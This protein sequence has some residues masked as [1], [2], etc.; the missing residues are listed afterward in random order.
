MKYIFDFDEV[1]LFTHKHWTDHA[2]VV[3]EKAGI[4]KG[5]VEEYFE[6]EQFNLF[7]MRKMLRDLSAP[8]KFYEE[9]MN[10]VKKFKNEGLVEIISKLGKSNCYILTY[11]D[12]EFQLDKIK[13]TGIA[14][15]FFEILVVPKEEKKETVEKICALY[16]YEEVIFVDDKAKNF[17]DLDFKKCS[18]L[19]TILY[20]GQDLGPFLSTI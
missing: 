11:G 14:H 8:D 12:E 5:L 4:P 6:K 15:L 13:R 20:K 3:L 19:R 1:I 10:E 17:Q 18:N 2:L 16:K 7:S 9:I